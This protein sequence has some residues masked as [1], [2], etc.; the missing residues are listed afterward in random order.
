MTIH[1][2][3]SLQL[4][5]TE[6]QCL[7]KAYAD[8][9]ASRAEAANVLS[10]EEKTF[11]PPI[12]AIGGTKYGIAGHATSSSVVNVCVTAK[13][14]EEFAAPNMTW[15]SRSYVNHKASVMVNLIHTHA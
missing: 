14:Y 13:D 2:N 15:R 4:T 6:Q 10:I 11:I 1:V 5:A 12:R 8:A 3:F 7:A 9:N